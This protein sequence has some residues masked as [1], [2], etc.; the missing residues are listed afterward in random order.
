MRAHQP[1]STPIH[2]PET[3]PNPAYTPAPAP[4]RTPTKVPEK[5]P[6]KVID[7]ELSAAFFFP[8]VNAAEPTQPTRE[9][10]ADTALQCKWPVGP[11]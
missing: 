9:A 1:G 7:S 4:E 10:R 6:E 8:P 11:R 2:I 3:V 5:V